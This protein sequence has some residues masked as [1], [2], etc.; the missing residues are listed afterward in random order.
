[1]YCS[2]DLKSHKQEQEKIY[3]FLIAFKLSHILTSTYTATPKSLLEQDKGN[4]V[5]D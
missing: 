4:T 2:R 1:M 5:W 3:K